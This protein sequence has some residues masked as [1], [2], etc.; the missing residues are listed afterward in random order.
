M[1]MTVKTLQDSLLRHVHADADLH[2]DSRAVTSGD[3]FIAL[4]GA[5]HPAA[6]F[7]ADAVAS[8]A[9]VVV[10]EESDHIDTQA[11]SVPLVQVSGLK[12]ML[13][14]L[15][16]EWYGRPSACVK[17]LAVTGTNG[18]T[19]T[20]QWLVR[21]LNDAGHAAGAIGTLGVTWPDG[22]QSS[23]ALTTP[24]VLSMHRTL[25]RM[26]AA[27]AQFVALEASSIGIVQGRLD[28]VRIAMAAF[29]NL[30]RDHLDFHGDMQAYEQAKR[31]LFSWPGLQACVI[32]ADDPAGRRIMGTV[33]HALTYSVDPT[34]SATVS[35]RDIQPTSEGQ[36][37]HLVLPA[38][39]VQ[40]MTALLGEH[41]VYNLLLVAGVLHQ[42]G[43]SF[44]QVGRAISALDAVEGRMQA[45]APLAPNDDAD[46]RSEPSGSMQGHADAAATDLPRRKSARAP[47]VVV[48]YA[49]TPDA[50]ERAL[51]A[52]AP[53]VAARGGRLICLFGCGGDRDAGKRAEMARSAARLAHEVV[54][55]S[56][57][58]RS[59]SPERIVADI[60][61]G[62]PADARWS[63]VLDRPAA[64]MNTIW[65]ADTDD[66]VLLA[67]KGH[68]TYQEIS[69]VREP[70]DD[71]EWARLAMLLPQVS[72][73]SSDTRNIGENELFVALTGPSFD[74]HDY[75][76]QAHARGACAAVVAHRMPSAMPQI[77]L[78]PT[79]RAL[80]RMGAAWRL[81]HDIP[82][83]A[84][85]GSN[86]KTTTKE[87]VSAILAQWLGAARRL[88]TAGNF[89]NEIGV[90]LTLLRLRDDHDAAVIE[91][92][93]NHPGEIERL[94]D[95]TQASVALVTN[96]QREHQEFMQSVEAVARENGMVFT[97]LAGVQATAAGDLT[98]PSVPAS[99]AGA[100]VYPCD[101]D[102]AWVWDDMSRGARRLTFGLT[103]ACDVHAQAVQSDDQGTTCS[104]VTPAG[105]ATLKLQVPG[106]H[107]LR[108]ALGA[109]AACLQAGAPLCAC[110]EGLAGFEAVSGRMQ[111]RR[112][113]DGT[114]LIDDTYN[115]NPDSVRAAVDVLAGLPAPRALVLGDMGE[116]G[117]NGPAMHH[118]VGAY[119]QARGI[120]MMF[121]LGEAS[122]ASAR[123]FGAKAKP[124]G[125]VEDV[126]AALLQAKP[127]SVLVK[128]SRFMRMERVVKG[129]TGGQHA[130]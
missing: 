68:E 129:F 94:A 114:V 26:H 81:R 87:M 14:E 107:N 85:A 37:F 72:G 98:S 119:A 88:A 18:K 54:V 10:C 38:G 16:D 73:V 57:N 65:Q 75:L 130:A 44:A 35:A 106:L 77:V 21:A 51:S 74:G 63:V 102:Y 96:A 2:L 121:T 29:T 116:V 27:G 23:G 70:M 71:R 33:A 48:D 99:V 91:L 31:R 79:G 62:F 95:M 8:G 83:I 24:D 78:G 22:T 124:C 93:M 60:V 82:V 90:P 17:V 111:S 55:T 104:V 89:N 123:A 117:E 50:L 36:R 42:L 6:A 66:V 59:E 109:I 120:D 108:N 32:N 12:A 128:G 67:G 53:V 30:S 47:L 40:I 64:I 80:M 3:V 45:V 34:V 105:T 20:V 13:G 101:D 126:V 25:A 11:C 4:G 113:D 115:A 127:A 39:D 92:G 28:G 56:D 58:P 5:R 86:G 7:I 76:D 122:L 103:Q 110:I 61:A 112:L 49:H 19:S 100:A 43:W 125:S 1:S 97:C 46:V 69:G 41:N 84:V 118:E 15:A 9:K 52:L